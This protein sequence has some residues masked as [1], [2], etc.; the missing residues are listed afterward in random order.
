[1]RHPAIFEELIK[2]RGT[3]EENQYTIAHGVA[4]STTMA[5][6]ITPHHPLVKE[7]L[8]YVPA[9]ND[10]KVRE[11]W[12]KL[13]HDQVDKA[14]H[15]YQPL[16]HKQKMMDQVFRVQDLDALAASI[17]KSEAQAQ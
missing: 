8:D 12:K 11:L 14:M 15:V 4:A 1:M 13:V 6:D 16:F 2:T 3:A 17:K 10:S 9:S 5:M 7:Y